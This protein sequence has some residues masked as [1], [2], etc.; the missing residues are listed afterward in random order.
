[1]KSD[2]SYRLLILGDPNSIYVSGYGAQLRDHFGQEITLDLLATFPQKKKS[3]ASIFD[4]IFQDVGK[5]GSRFSS[6]IRKMK[7]PFFIAGKLN[8]LKG[9][10]DCIH[11]LYC[12][13]DLMIIR[14]ILRKAA[15]RL[16]LTVF[17][18]DYREL[19]GWKK[20]C[21]AGVFRSADQVTSNNQQIINSIIADYNISH[22]KV[23]L[24][25]FGFPILE[26]I[27]PDQPERMRE[28][29]HYLGIPEGKLVVCIGYNYD[30][31]Q[32]HIAVI[33]SVNKCNQLISYHD[34]VFFLFP[35]TYGT[36][37]NYR[38]ELLERLQRFPFSYMVIDTFLPET[39]IAHLRQATDILVQVQRSDSFSA[40]TL[41]HMY[42][43]NLL[44]TGSWLP[45]QDLLEAGIYFRQVSDPGEI[46]SELTDSLINFKAEQFKCR[47]NS[48]KIYQM[49]SWTTNLPNWLA[50]YR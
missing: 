3:S 6:I 33:E 1:L 16:I 2:K 40:S 48:G 15:P 25:R 45:Y 13:Q 26:L 20:R 22:K 41:E 14:R 5:S 18:S 34:N 19:S 29:R 7:R 46:G 8:Q 17:G 39:G 49:C 47:A 30:P 27:Y 21:F 12:I 32:Q 36:D 4:T 43:G 24:C 42:A 11:V 50:L 9:Q 23:T 10:Y 38:K 37:E 31:I 28:S 35:M 44:L